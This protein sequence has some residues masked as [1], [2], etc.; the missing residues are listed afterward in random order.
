MLYWHTDWNQD[1]IQTPFKKETLEDRLEETDAE[2]TDID[3]LGPKELTRINVQDH[4][5]QEDVFF[6][7]D[8]SSAPSLLSIYD[9]LLCT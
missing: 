8:P 2:E 3:V 1:W 9:K 7:Y 4:T 6:D 5:T